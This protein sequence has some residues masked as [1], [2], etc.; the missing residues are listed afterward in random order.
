MENRYAIV[1]ELPNLDYDRAVEAIV[2]L[3]KD[4]GFGVLTRPG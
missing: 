4:E 1:R 3:L 2:P